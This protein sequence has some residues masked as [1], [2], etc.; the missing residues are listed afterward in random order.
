MANNFFFFF[1]IFVCNIWWVYKYLPFS[2][3]SHSLL[4]QHSV[5]ICG[6]HLLHLSCRALS[7][8]LTH[9]EAA[10]GHS[11]QHLN[12]S[13]TLM[14]QL[15]VMFPEKLICGQTYCPP[16][17]YP[18]EMIN[19][20]PSFSWVKILFPICTMA[21]WWLDHHRCPPGEGKTLLQLKQDRERST[22]PLP[23]NGNLLHFE[24]IRGWRRQSAKWDNAQENSPDE[25]CLPQ[26]PRPGAQLQAE[27][28][29]TVP[30]ASYKPWN[31]IL[32]SFNIDMLT[33]RKI[34]YDLAIKFKV[35]GFF[36]LLKVWKWKISFHYLFPW[37]ITFIN[38]WH[39]ISLYW[40]T[41][42][43]E[44]IM[45]WFPYFLFPHPPD[46]L[47]AKEDAVKGLHRVENKDTWARGDVRGYT[48]H[49]RAE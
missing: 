45:M 1:F 22:T 34:N 18:E 40:E 8:V 29:R 4:T 3:H 7:Q 2:H 41:N 23:N 37:Y 17:C 35:L 12:K 42:L 46:Q 11:D 25:C 36:F 5:C 48:G 26:K 49:S 19:H 20:L 15:E 14:Y 9:S 43:Y 47:E 16:T 38:H 39:S 28:G 24:F 32:A 33:T 10:A 6:G 31:S 21:L 44:Q 30:T 13:S 27:V